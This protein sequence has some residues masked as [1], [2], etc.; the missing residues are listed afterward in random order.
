MQ[1]GLPL[2]LSTT[3]IVGLAALS[4]THW[5]RENISAPPPLLAFALGVMPNLAAAF[6]MPLVLASFFPT[7]QVSPLPCSLVARTCGFSCLRRSDS[8]AGSLY[9]H[10]ANAL[11]LMRMTSLQQDSVQS[12]HTSRS[13]GTFAGS[14][15]AAARLLV[16]RPNPSLNR[17]RNGVPVSSIVRL[18][19]ANLLEILNDSTAGWSR[20]PPG[21]FGH[22]EV[23]LPDRPR[24][25]PVSPAGAAIGVPAEI[26]MVWSI[27][28]PASEN[29]CGIWQYSQQNRARS[30]TSCRNLRSIIQPSFAAGIGA[31]LTLP[32][33][34]NC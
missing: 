6:A 18:P 5:M 9:K 16:V 8:W 4:A 24:H 1:I 2:R 30:R 11:C 32:D 33:P 15:S 14:R 23:S 27:S 13:V 17:T 28:C 20:R 19:M 31:L 34:K 21:V 10:E 7:R 25:A 22:D 29:T 3:G 12:S 26:A